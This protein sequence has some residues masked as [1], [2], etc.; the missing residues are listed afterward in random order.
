MK[1][2]RNFMLVA[3]VAL[4]V[5]SLWSVAG[6]YAK[7]TTNGS[8]SDSARVAKFGVKVTDATTDAN[9]IFTKTRTTNGLVVSADTN[10]V[11][12]GMSGSLAGFTITGTPEVAVEL[13]VELE[14]LE[15]EN[16]TVADGEEYMP[17]VFTVNGVDYKIDENITS[18]E[19]LIDAVSE[20]VAAYSAEFEAGT[21]LSTALDEFSFSWRWEFEG[22]DDIKDTILADA[23]VAPTISVKVKV[24]VNQIE[25]LKNPTV[26]PEQPEEPVGGEDENN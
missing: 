5:V 25:T 16:W 21:D 26:S 10:V 23:E 12:P 17:L 1:K 14:E 2:A 20:A 4:T 8:T 6:T 3:L 15:L 19:M 9:T 22:N 7:Y 18:V 13:L 11:A 24:T